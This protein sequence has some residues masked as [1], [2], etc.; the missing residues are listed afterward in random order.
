[1]NDIELTTMFAILNRAKEKVLCIRRKKSW[2]GWAF[3]GG[4][5]ENGEC[6]FQCAR[7]E[8]EEETGIDASN[9]FFKGIVNIFNTETKKRHIIMNYLVHC[10]EDK[11]TT[12]CD[13]GEIAWIDYDKL[14]QLEL[15]EGM[16]QR[17]QVFFEPGVSELYIE[18]DEINGYTKVE[19]FKM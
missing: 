5:L 18:W 2:Q 7:R 19:V 17:F 12:L 8:M 3:P 16:E 4:H 14:E 1:M 13:E 15:A 9:I 11:L 6:F 10:S